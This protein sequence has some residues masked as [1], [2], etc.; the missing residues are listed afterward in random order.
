MEYK[1]S[2]LISSQFSYP[3]WFTDIRIHGFLDKLN[4]F[5]QKIFFWS[6]TPV[7]NG[8]AIDG[9]D[10]RQL[11]TKVGRRRWSRSMILVRAREQRNYICV[12]YASASLF[13][14]SEIQQCI[15]ISERRLLSSN[16]AIESERCA[17]SCRITGIYE[18]MRTRTRYV[19]VRYLIQATFLI[20]SS[21]VE[22]WYVNFAR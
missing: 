12:F 15:G 14:F 20:R 7:I 13:V 21:Y 5:W 4:A 1:N 9:G 10:A 11:F 2:F 19:L 22:A 17:L 18:R 6:R 3:L 8:R 16:Y